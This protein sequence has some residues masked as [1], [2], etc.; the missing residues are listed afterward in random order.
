MGK[1][2]AETSSTRFSAVV[3]LALA[4]TA[5]VLLALGDMI[6]F[7]TPVA[8]AVS[9][10]VWIAG[11]VLLVW[12]MIVGAASAAGL[13]RE[14]V[15]RRRPMLRDTVLVAAVAVVIIGTIAVQ[16]LAGTGSAVG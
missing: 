2:E 13:I 3:S 15:A 6:G 1:S 5:A 4:A 10:A 9:T 8:E 14:A 12:A 7:R 16:P 11:W